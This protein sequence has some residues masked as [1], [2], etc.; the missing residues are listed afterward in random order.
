MEDQ[1]LIDRIGFLGGVHPADGPLSTDDTF[2][3]ERMWEFALNLVEHRALTMGLMERALPGK[4]VVLLHPDSEVVACALGDLKHLFHCLTIAEASMA[5]T[6]WLRTFVK[7]LVW[8]EMVWVRE[9]LV[10]LWE[11]DFARVPSDV[12]QEIC[13]YTGGFMTTKS[14]EDSF[15]IIRSKE[16]ASKS[17]KLQSKSAWH[18]VQHAAVAADCDRKL[19]KITAVAKQM[20]SD[21]GSAT[22][23]LPRTMFEAHSVN[24][25][26]GAEEMRTLNFRTDW[27]SYGGPQYPLVAL[28]T[29]ALAAADA[30]PSIL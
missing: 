9:L 15:N 10:A 29:E 14:V 4:L 11:V 12:R 13:K 17:G 27:V 8:P 22:A 19:V 26:L 5:T 1:D 2:L 7:E 24:F 18:L 28:A 21:A 3:A 6:R 20:V 30:D 25:S 16:S 23:A